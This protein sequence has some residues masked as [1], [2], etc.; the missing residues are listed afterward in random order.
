VPDGRG[1]AAV[2]PVVAGLADV[3]ANRPVG[4]DTWFQLAS[5]SKPIAAADALARFD[6]TAPLN[7][8][9]EEAA[10]PWRL[11]AAAGADAAWVDQVTVDRLVDHSSLTLHYVNGVA[12]D[13]PF[14]TTLELVDGSAA[15]LGYPAQAVSKEPDTHFAYSGRR[16]CL[17]ETRPVSTD[18]C[19]VGP[20]ASPSPHRRR[21]VSERTRSQTPSQVQR[22][23]LPRVA[24]PR[25]G[26]D[27]RRVRGGPRV[28][29]SRRGVAQLRLYGRAVFA[30]GRLP[31]RRRGGR[32]RPPPLPRVR[33]RRGAAP[34]RADSY[35]SP[36]CRGAQ[37]PRV[38]KPTPPSFKSRRAPKL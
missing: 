33:G 3:A 19:G 23:R 4:A 1:G 27:G 35:V 21:S 25:R 11:G 12:P 8:L 5:L 15:A 36:R 17:G 38:A 10:S 26:R 18:F 9:L 24:A 29:I 7:A 34:A 13:A 32:R 16:R 37:E 28:S 14:P 6:R 22:R 2:E 31:R 20:R 30:R